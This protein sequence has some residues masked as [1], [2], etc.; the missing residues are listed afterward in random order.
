M[1]DKVQ[2]VYL[3]IA[4]QLP[5]LIENISP[6]GW[7]VSKKNAGKVTTFYACYAGHFMVTAVAKSKSDADNVTELLKKMDISV[8][9]GTMEFE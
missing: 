4:E 9:D 2:H 1:S 8:Y 6:V 5:D 7:L 3:D